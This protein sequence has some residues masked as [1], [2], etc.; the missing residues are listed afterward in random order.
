MPTA[1]HTDPPERELDN[2]PHATRLDR[3]M[4]TLPDLNAL[5]VFA[6]V[7]DAQGFRGAARALGIPK[8]TV[9]RKLAE[10]ESQLGLRLVQRTTR[11]ISLTDAGESFYRQCAPALAALVD[12]QKCLVATQAAPRGQLRITAPNTFAELFLGPVLEDY[13]RQ[14]REVR[15]TVDLTDRY[16]DLIAEGFD[17]AIR[18]GELPDS[19]LVARALGDAEAQASS[20][21]HCYASP[22]Y[23]A[24]HGAPRHPRELNAHDCLF[25]GS[26]E[27]GAKW[28]F[29]THRRRVPVPVRPRITCTSFYL[30]LEAAIAGHGITRLPAFFASEAQRK[31]KLVPVL[32][33][34]AL[35]AMPLHAVYPSSRNVAPPVRAFLE[36]LTRH[37]ADAPWKS[38]VV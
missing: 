16:V 18:A 24:T 27:R 21:P 4:D 37:F 25:Y 13:Y 32:E 35:P 2:L 36:L 28:T 31:G 10:L 29:V 11:K 12:A 6:A 22:E 38:V 9:S 19:T 8:S 3:L 20:R 5:Q 15:V 7:V 14:Y 33:D 1:V 30:L 23:L 34:F 26:S 17:L